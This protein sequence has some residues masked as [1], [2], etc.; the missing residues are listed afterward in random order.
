M[1][2]ISL[3]F[4]RSLFDIDSTK[5]K[6]TVL[7]AIISYLPIIFQ[8]KLSQF[9]TTD[10]IPQLKPINTEALKTFGPFVVRTKVGMF[11]KSFP[12]F[13]I[14]KNT[15]LVD[16]IIWFEFNGEE[17]TL[18]KIQKF[19]IDNGK[20][21][22]QSPPEIKLINNQVFAKYNVIFELKTDL[23]FYKFPF[24]DHRLP[25]VLSNDF[26]T[27]NEMIF[28]VDASS[29]QIQPNISPAGWRFQDM[30]VDAGFLDLQLDRQ[31]KSKKTENPKALF[32]LNFVKASARKALV[33][34]IPL[35]SATFLSLLAFVMNAANV[36]GKFSIAITAL[37]ALL[38]YRFVIEQMMPAVGYLT[39]TDAIYLF[40]LFF[41]FIAFAIQILLTRYYM[42][43]ANKNPNDTQE[44]LERIN[45]I[46]FIIMTLL[47]VGVTTYIIL[48]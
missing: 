32:V 31:D 27:P 38:G 12:L 2:N 11:I 7:I 44:K 5:F 30:S 23:N 18:E 29:F 16:A 6:T 10:P 17:V 26:V 36:V 48:I 37:T 8:I 15:F 41:A 19:S 21:T 1:K 43:N 14:N 35:Y 3:H 46:I 13:D 4:L 20:I 22:Y 33:I 24:E 34:F 40:L 25:I 39:T 47:L 28:T 42:V 9:N 45:S